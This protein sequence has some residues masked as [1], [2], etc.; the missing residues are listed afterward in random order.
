M[1]EL[2]VNQADKDMK[3]QVHTSFYVADQVPA[4]STGYPRNLGTWYSYSELLGK[5]VTGPYWIGNFKLPTCADP[6]LSHLAC[7][8]RSLGNPVAFFSDI[9]EHSHFLVLYNFDVKVIGWK[10]GDKFYRD[11][12]DRIEK[13][14]WTTRADLI[15]A[16]KYR[17]QVIEKMGG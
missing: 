17:K 11:A 1:I 14:V 12:R 2:V 7:E 3:K 13:L 16:D 8:R 10:N 15:E 5:G 4:L 6:E 9:G